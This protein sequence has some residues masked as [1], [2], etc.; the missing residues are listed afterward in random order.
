LSVTVIVFL[1]TL[2]AYNTK[3]SVEKAIVQ[4]G[5]G[6]QVVAG[7]VIARGGGDTGVED[8]G[9]DGV[10]GDRGIKVAS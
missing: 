5:G 1:E 6:G 8:S 3:G 4:G 10:E 9:C 7:D 2:S